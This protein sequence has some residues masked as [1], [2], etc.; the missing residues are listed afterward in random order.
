ME[1]WEDFCSILGTHP[2]L[3]QLDLGSSILSEWAMK[4]MCLKLKNQACKVQ[5]LTFKNAEVVSGLRHLWMT[6]VSN[7]NLK[8]LHLGNTLMEENDIKLACQALQHPK[9]SLETLRLDSCELMPVSCHILASALCGNRTLTHLCMSD[10]SLRTEE[11]RRLCRFM[12]NPECA[13]QR[14]ILKQCNL[15]GDAYGFLALMLSHNGKLTHLNLTMNPV[16]D[17]GMK[18]LCDAIKKPTCHLQEL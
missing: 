9:C 18:L 6:L 16:E 4:I 7:R 10:N 15:R 17:G 2:K 12:S 11:V 14:L 5:S 1:C 13:L 3:K 8:Y